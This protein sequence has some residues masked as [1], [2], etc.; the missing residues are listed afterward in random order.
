MLQRSK[1]ETCDVNRVRR[2]ETLGV[3]SAVEFRFCIF[4]TLTGLGSF[5][6]VWLRV[7]SSI[8]RHHQYAHLKQLWESNSAV[9]VSPSNEHSE[10]AH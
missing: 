1:K 4:S 9:S 3:V 5:L 8:N 10:Y 7:F 6:R 2:Q